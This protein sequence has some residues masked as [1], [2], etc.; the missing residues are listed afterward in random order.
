MKAMK[1]RLCTIGNSRRIRAIA[2]AG[3]A[4]LSAAICTPSRMAI[5]A[6]EETAA[7]QP[8][9]GDVTIGD[10]TMHTKGPYTVFLCPFNAKAFNVTGTESETITPKFPNGT[11]LAWSW[12]MRGEPSVIGFLQ[13]AGY[14]NY[15]NTVPQTPIGPK[16]VNQIKTLTVSH[17]L[18]F[19]GTDNG[20]NVIYDYFLTKTPNGNDDH[21]FEIE[22]F[23]HT[24]DF[25]AK[26]V[27]SVT[28]VGETTISDVR[29]KVA[30]DD[31]AHPA[32]ILFMPTSKADV[33]EGKFDL[34]A[35]HDYLISKG[36]ITGD[37]YYNGHSLGVE[38]G[39]G[40]GKLVVK[41]VSVKYQ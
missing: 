18:S 15:Y 41:S 7:T 23:V 29:W 31:H 4:L 6:T 22:V 39:Q 2:F 1:F 28:P 14:G 24:S 16:Q 8:A 10:M 32:D 19:S 13:V 9:S 21:L 27:E 17:N 26:Y 38:T 30:I 35:M 12:P 11:A 34:K 36:K 37:E 33:S 3:V 5:A 20:F 25:A 40:S